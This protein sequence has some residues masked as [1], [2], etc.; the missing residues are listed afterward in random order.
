[1]CRWLAYAG[2]PI[3]LSDVLHTPAHSL[4]D[5][6]LYSKLA[7][8]TTNGDGFGVG[9]CNAAPAPGVFRSVEPA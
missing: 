5:R 3:V 8:G 9:W 2:S 7:A 4:I 6:S 1:M